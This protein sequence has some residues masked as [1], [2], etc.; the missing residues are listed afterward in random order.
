M[1]NKAFIYVK[2]T[3]KM[4]AVITHFTVVARRLVRTSRG[5]GSRGRTSR[6]RT[7]RTLPRS[8]SPRQ[9][10]RPTR[11]RCPRSPRRWSTSWASRSFGPARAAT[12]APRDRRSSTSCPSRSFDRRAPPFPQPSF[13]PA[14]PPRRRRP[15]Y[16][17][18]T[19]PHALLLNL[20]CL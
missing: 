17:A 3:L 5:S 12:C 7:T 9:R 1:T 10:P 15:R 8:A 20:S 14:P 11:S 18:L 4:V 19:C 13:P 2:T 6:R 16:V